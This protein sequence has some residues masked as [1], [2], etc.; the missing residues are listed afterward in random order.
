MRYLLLSVLVVSLVGILIFSNGEA[1]ASH[2]TF[3]DGIIP[4]W[5]GT[6]LEDKVWSSKTYTD[7]ENRFSIEYPS[8]WKKKIL[9]KEEGIL[10]YRDNSGLSDKYVAMSQASAFLWVIP[11]PEEERDSKDPAFDDS[12]KLSVV[13]TVAQNMKPGGFIKETKILKLDTKRKAFSVSNTWLEP[14]SATQNKGK[15]NHSMFSNIVNIYT[16][17]MTWWIFSQ[18]D[19]YLQKRS[20]GSDDYDNTFLPM[21][22]SFNDSPGV[23]LVRN[24]QGEL[25]TYDSYL[26]QLEAEKNKYHPPPGVVS[27]PSYGKTNFEYDSGVSVKDMYEHFGYP[28]KNYSFFNSYASIDT[29]GVEGDVKIV[30]GSG[31]DLL[32]YDVVI[33][34][35]YAE[36]SEMFFPLNFMMYDGKDRSFTTITSS[37]LNSLSGSETKNPNFS[38][39]EDCLPYN[40]RVQPGLW[41]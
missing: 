30:S 33:S 6:P 7:P 17:D 5:I 18:S 38:W 31:K 10:F 2:L 14:F 40:V 35:R 23:K 39:R 36:K 41:A 20:F 21:I 8:H 9:F 37:T 11:G 19:N 1:E 13:K 3:T 34:P 28:Q 15:G 24:S 22:K 27:E 26:K 4:K 29:E 32:V 16:E 12:A 25:V